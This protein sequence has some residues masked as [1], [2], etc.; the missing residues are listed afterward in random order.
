MVPRRDNAPVS[1]GDVR[2]DTW[3]WAVRLFKTRQDAAEAAGGGRVDA[4]GRRSKPGKPVR[5]GDVLEVTKGPV[6]TTVVVRGLVR[7]RVS[8]TEAAG[9]YEET[10][11]SIALRERYQADRRAAA[12]SAPVPGGRPTKRDRRRWDRLTGG[13]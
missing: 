7:R 8:A 4:N 9:L 5:V 11:A 13:S 1:D 12:L 10:P 6:R 2:T 3:L